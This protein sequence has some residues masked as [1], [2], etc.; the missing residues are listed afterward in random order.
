MEIGVTYC[1]L[2]EVE[3]FRHLESSPAIHRRFGKGIQRELPAY[4]N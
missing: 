1:N 3:T 2:D 4:G